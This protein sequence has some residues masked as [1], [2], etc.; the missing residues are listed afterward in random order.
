MGMLVEKSD[1]S[2]VFELPVN[3]L[4]TDLLDSVITEVEADVMRKLLGDTVFINFEADYTTEN[5]FINLIAGDDYV[6][7][8][9]TTRFLG[10]KEAM[11]YFVWFYFM[12]EQSYQATTQG[13]LESDIDASRKSKKEFSVLCR[14]FN[15][16]V[17]IYNTAITYINEYLIGE[18]DSENFTE[19]ETESIEKMTWI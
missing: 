18:M 2:G 1:F 5:D 9:K 3:T 16:G 4:N 7:G 8:T 12:R 10:M 14:Y 11:K 17:D 15:K 13:V 6:I 19:I